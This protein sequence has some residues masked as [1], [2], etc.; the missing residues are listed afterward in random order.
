MNKL[1][2][3]PIKECPFY[4]KYETGRSSGHGAFGERE[5]DVYYTEGVK[6]NGK[7]YPYTN[8][9]YCIH[10]GVKPLDVKN[11]EMFS[12]EFKQ[13]LNPIQ[14]E[15]EIKAE[16]ELYEKLKAKFDK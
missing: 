8:N 16:K 5:V 1:I 4:T 3:E 14:Y 9:M 11:W 7:L 10:N 2:I 6:L 12:D 13:M 15:Q